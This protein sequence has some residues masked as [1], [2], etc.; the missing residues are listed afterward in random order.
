MKKFLTI[1]I[2]LVA[3]LLSSCG[4]N[5]GDSN[6]KDQNSTASS[7]T[8]SDENTGDV[9]SHVD[10]NWGVQ[11]SIVAANEENMVKAF[12]KF[13]SLTGI[14]QGTGK[15][16]YQPD[17]TLVILDS[18]RM[19]GSPEVTD[20]KILPAYFEQTVKIFREYRRA[21]YSD[22]DFSISEQQTVK[23][24][25]YDMVKYI[26]THTCKCDGEPLELKFA[27]YSTKL[28][29]NDACIYWMVLDESED[30]SL[31]QTILEYAEKMAES[32]HE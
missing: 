24:N 2:I 23:V 15:I 9:T 22:F 3:L 26:G 1:S 11:E 5:N 17:Q 19:S 4:G 20:G 29:A 21:N 16:A 7:D 32:L 25:D 6:S 12:I 31:S 8:V 30:Q 14:V 27:A 28:K 18:Q 13:P 10:E